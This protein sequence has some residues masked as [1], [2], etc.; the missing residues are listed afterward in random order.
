[1]GR[2][3]LEPV[4][5]AIVESGLKL[6]PGAAVSI[7]LPDGDQVKGVAVAESDAARAEAPARGSGMVEPP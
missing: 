1:V 7:A 4:F 6:F 3:L 2:V 5:D